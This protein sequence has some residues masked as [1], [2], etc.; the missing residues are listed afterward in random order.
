[1]S[2]SHVIRPSASGPAPAFAR[3]YVKQAVN[4]IRALG[5]HGE[6]R[7]CLDGELLIEA[8]RGI[9]RFF[10]ITKNLALPVWGALDDCLAIRQYQRPNPSDI[11]TTAI[12]RSLNSANTEVLTFE[13]CGDEG[14]PIDAI[15]I[16]PG[17]RIRRSANLLWREES[18]RVPHSRCWVLRLT[19]LIPTA[20][21]TTEICDRLASHARI[22]MLDQRISDSAELCE[23]MADLGWPRHAF[24]QIVVFGV[25]CSVS[26]EGTRVN[27]W[28]A[29]TVA[30]LSASLCDAIGVLQHPELGAGQVMAD[31]DHAFGQLR[32]DSL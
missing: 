6:I 21:S 13:P 11:A 17:A 7:E 14:G 30:C 23:H 27:V 1:M 16:R 15:C 3:G 20:C 2:M 12:L 8:H 31:V 22:L 26:L 9:F 28:A 25:D 32:S 5:W 4:I 10:S 18:V 19:S 29:A 24:P